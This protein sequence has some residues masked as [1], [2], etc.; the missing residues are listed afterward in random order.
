MI[1][2][3][4]LNNRK[5]IL[6]SDGIADTPPKFLI[7]SLK[8]KKGLILIYFMLYECLECATES[9]EHVSASWV[10]C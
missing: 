8:E 2:N 6:I 1:I 4:I 10:I 5:N 3:K 9:M 7:N